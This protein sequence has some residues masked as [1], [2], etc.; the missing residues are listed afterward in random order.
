MH[1]SA[2]YLGIPY[3]EGESSDAACDC[4]GLV[5]LVLHREKGYDLP[6]VAVGQPV[7]NSPAI[8]QCLDEWKMAKDF[9][10]FDAV[11]MKNALGHHI[12]IVTRVHGDAVYILHCNEP[13][14]NIMQLSDMQRLGYRDFRV[15]R[16]G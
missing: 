6:A 5:R 13:Y 11:T 14:S 3:K 2:N 9:R 4:W 8:K 1:W 12:G 10:E 15:W 16:H 7:D